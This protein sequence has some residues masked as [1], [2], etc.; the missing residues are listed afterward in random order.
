MYQHPYASHP[1][2]ASIRRSL[3][4]AA[5]AATAVP[6]LALAQDADGA[7]EPTSLDQITVTGSRIRG[8]ESAGG[9]VLGVGREQIDFSSSVS[10]TDILREVPQ[11]LNLGTDESHKGTQNAQLNS[12]FASGVNLRGIG[13]STTLPLLNGRR[14]VASGTQGQYTDPSS[15]PAI[16][17]ERVEVLADGASALYGSDAVAGV[18]NMITRQDYE[19]NETQVRYG[20][21]DGLDRMQVSHLFGT[22]WNTGSLMVAVEH[23]K[24]SELKASDRSFYRE[25][26]TDRGGTDFRGNLCNPGTLVVGGNN[27]ALPGGNGLG[28]D[29][30]SLVRGTTNRCDSLALGWLLPEQERDSVF[31]DFSQQ[32]GERVKLRFESLYS[33]REFDH[34]AGGRTASITLRD[35]NPYFV[36]PVPGATS[37]SINYM[38]PDEFGRARSTGSARVF[39]SVLG[40]DAELWGDWRGSIN[41]IYGQSEDVIDVRNIVNANNVAT[42][43]AS[44][45][46]SQAFN[47]YGSGANTSAQVYDFIRGRTVQKPSTTMRMFEAQADGSLFSMWGGDAR[48]AVGAE[49]REEELTTPF[50]TYRPGFPDVLT[51]SP[52]SRDVTSAYAEAYLPFVG[53][54]NARPGI[55]RLDLSLALRHDRYSDFGS[56]TNPKVGLTWAPSK[57]L[58]VRATYGESYRAPNLSELDASNVTIY[59]RT[60]TDPQAGGAQSLGILL[61]G[62]N[63]GLDAETA[64]TW[65]AGV[66]WRPEFAPGLSLNATYWSVDYTG[67]VVDLF[68]VNDVLVQ[69]QFYAQHIT[70]NP[71]LDQVN[72]L[73]NAGYRLSGTVNPATNAFIIDARRQNLAVTKADGIDFSANQLWS[74]DRGSLTLGVNATYYNS[75]DTS[76]AQGATIVDRVDTINYPVDLTVRAN[77]G[78]FDNNWSARLSVAHIG[79]YE[80]TSSRLQDDVASWTTADIYVG[81][82][83]N[84]GNA[85]TDGLTLSL[86][87][88]NLF[89]RN[90]NFVD[91]A[92][93]Y[94]GEKASALGRIAT[95]G[96][97]KRW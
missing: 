69:E 95:I 7:Q 29:P 11:V 93:G 90:P 13:G 57:N 1:L 47:P 65:T 76:A 8:V 85:F 83:F 39:Q 34:I 91:I 64:K 25:D 30:A 42:A 58:S 71:S 60:R 81:Y 36:S 82:R 24:R 59:Q 44:A 73:L 87:V 20:A 26:L 27:Y 37:V 6:T 68:S 66:D 21:G 89:D 4:L 62:G 97:N 15:I 46:P 16:A 86:D 3:L 41:A 43:G 51:N 35:T 2:A 10:T 19:G 32:L 5:L 80:N 92:G 52:A 96:I 54:A 12:S 78:W 50:L 22:A 28:I 84:G 40:L 74:L 56:T 75:Y 67:Q 9:N 72:A 18:V 79:G 77:L 48:L 55:E 23:Q 33:K 63:P 17:I 88:Q 45:D 70:R 49:Y 14:I 53:K 94:D 31:V 61:A 38:M